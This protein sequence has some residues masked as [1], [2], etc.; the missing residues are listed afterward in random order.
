MS[1]E[2]VRTWLEAATA[3]AGMTEAE[4]LADL[5]PCPNG[6]GRTSE[7]P[8]GGPCKACWDA[9]PMPGWEHHYG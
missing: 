3:C 4:L 8:Y 7:D 9:V 1:D 6:C 5:G 2:Q